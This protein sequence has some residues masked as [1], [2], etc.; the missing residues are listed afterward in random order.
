MPEKQW[1]LYA[2]TMPGFEKIS[3]LEIKNTLHKPKFTQFA[4]AKDQNGIILFDSDADLEQLLALRTTEDIFLTALHKT[5]MSRD[6]GDLRRIAN[7][8]FEGN[9]FA[10]ALAQYRKWFGLSGAVTY[11]VI[12]RKPGQHAFRRKDLQ[13]AIEYG[14]TRAYGHQ[15]Q[16]VDDDAQLEIWVNMLADELLCGLRL[17]DKTM[18]HRD[19]Q[20]GHV[21]ATLRPSA[22]ASMVR[23]SEPQA[24]DVFLDPMCGSGTILFE[25][26]LIA[27]SQHIMGGDIDAGRLQ[28][29]YDNL[30]QFP[31][32]DRI[33]CKKW[34][35][36]KLPI[37]DEAVTKIVTNPPF[38]KQI[39]NRKSL[40]KLYPA[41][42]R[43]FD[44]V[45]KPNGRIVIISSEYDLVKQTLRKHKNLEL[46]TGYSVALLGQWARVYI[47]DKKS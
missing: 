9:H 38:G 22:A 44:R 8:M 6:W 43:E 41:V 31:D 19:Y 27:D 21:S 13:A 1:A 26:A 17:S 32:A 42:F 33:Q 39:S 35:A 40:Y 37:D 15:Y 36:T 7:M 34:D 16:V 5:D 3:W 23:L 45:L 4:F 29:A 2:Q 10:M 25:R 20:T 28:I 14:M 11:R 12:A 47:I 24:D 18:R 30:A 46:R